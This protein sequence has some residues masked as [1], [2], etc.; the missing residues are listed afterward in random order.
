[1]RKSGVLMHISSLPSPHGIGS[2]GKPARDFVDFLDKAGQAY[3]QILP[4]CPTSYGDSPYQSFSTFAG[5]P[6]FIDLDELC[7]A[8]YLKRKEYAGIDWESE[9][10]RVNYEA[11][12]NKRYVVLRKAAERFLENPE[13]GYKEFCHDNKSWIYDYALFM[14]LKDANGGKSWL[15]W[16]EP[17]KKR[18]DDAI[19]IAKEEHKEDINFWIIM[20]YFFFKQWNELRAYANEKNIEIIGD[21]PIYV[22]LDSVDVWAN[23]GLFQ[24]D[25]NLNPTDVAGCPPDGFSAT[26]QLWGNPLFRWDVMKADGYKWWIKRIDAACRIY[27]VLRI[28]HFRGFDEY[29]AIPYGESTAENGT[30]M[31]GPGMKLFQ[32]IEKE[33][34][35]PEIIAEDL[36]F[37]TESVLQMLKESGFPGM[38]VLQFAFD[39]S[40]ESVYLPHRYSENCVVYT[41]THDNDTTRGWYRTLD[42]E[43]RDFAKEYMG[44]SRLDDDTLTW[45]FMRLAMGSAAQLCVTPIQDI[46]GIDGSGRINMPSTLGGNWTWQMEKGAFDKKIVHKLY[47]MT[48]LYGRLNEQIKKQPE[49]GMENLK[50]K[51]KRVGKNKKLRKE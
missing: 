51:E 1:M 36:G 15:E 13:D 42:K 35:R 49:P 40:G 11:L 48:Q 27:N 23:P 29:Y 38:K 18:Y 19:N 43:S 34:G 6:Y 39:P 45:D 25:D 50:C 44:V 3:W 2:M 24:L 5:N 46:L 41:G 14:A 10:D 4:V 9:P 32:A 47:R 8:G 31:P 17:L 21:L 30:W 12:Y 26:G 28:D 33:L 16:D 7:K 37:L 22:A 20:Q